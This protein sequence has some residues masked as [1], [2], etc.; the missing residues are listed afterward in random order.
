MEIHVLQRRFDLHELVAG[1]AFAEHVHYGITRDEANRD[2]VER[3]LD[4]GQLV[5]ANLLAS[6]VSTDLVEHLARIALQDYLAR[7]DDRH[8]AAQLAN[9][10]DDVR[11]EN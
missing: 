1:R 3:G 5:T 10:L 11:R 8:S 7:V 2:H 9:V 6:D 4:R